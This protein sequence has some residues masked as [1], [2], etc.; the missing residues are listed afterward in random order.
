MV[1]DWPSHIYIDNKYFEME[2]VSFRLISD[3]NSPGK[4]VYKYLKS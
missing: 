2:E 1:F 4:L 3:I